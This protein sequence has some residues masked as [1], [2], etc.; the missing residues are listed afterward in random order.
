MVDD[1]NGLISVALCTYNGEQYITQQIQ[2]ILNQTVLPDELIIC[3]DASTDLTLDLLEKVSALSP[4]PIHIYKNE[5][6]L[7]STK[8]FEKAINLCQG[9]IIILADQDDLWY[10]NKVEIFKD[11]FTHHPKV[12]A[13]FS[14]G[15]MMDA[16]GNNLGYTLWDAFK[17]NSTEQASLNKGKGFEV[18]LKHNVVTG[19]AMAFRTDYKKLIFPIPELWIHDGW[20]ILLLSAVGE[21]Q[22]IDQ[23]LIKYRKHALQQVGAVEPSLR[24]ELRKVKETDRSTYLLY[25]RQYLVALERLLS[26]YTHVKNPE[27]MR[28]LADKAKH[29]LV[30]ANID[31]KLSR[32]PI[33]SKELVTLNYFRYSN[34][35]RSFL[36][37]L[38]LY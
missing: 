9:D 4:I 33:I 26:V 10:E 11:Y 23:T 28:L 3:D 30:R 36:K 35:I 25:A 15:D 7:G 14:N 6:N 19:A 12:Q 1:K 5:H 16:N 22:C 29:L 21:I 18:L 31:R 37:D 38:F 34:G 32:L 13:A 8:N 20:I 2:S 27:T 24:H 17:L